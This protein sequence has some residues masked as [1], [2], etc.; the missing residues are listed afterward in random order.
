[1]FLADVLVGRY[2]QGD[3]T[4]QR[5]PNLPGNDHEL[6]D[7]T[8]NDVANPSIYVSYDREK[9]YPTYLIMYKS[10]GLLEKVP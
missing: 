9:C 1:M 10:K 7:S 2:T 8:V 4:M 6:Y 5:P 3:S